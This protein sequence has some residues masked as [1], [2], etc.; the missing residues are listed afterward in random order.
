MLR[1]DNNGKSV[2]EFIKWLT[3]KDA[4][5]YASNARNSINSEIVKNTWHNL[6]PN[7][8]FNDDDAIDFEGFSEKES[9]V[10]KLLDK[11]KQKMWICMK[12]ML[13]K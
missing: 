10:S 5:W 9:T 6:L 11:E 12:M 13:M 7:M 4:I 1:Y 2:V 3:I 8:I